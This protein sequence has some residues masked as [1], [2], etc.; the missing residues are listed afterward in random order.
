MSPYYD[1]LLFLLLLICLNLM[2]K[3]KNERESQ[4]DESKTRKI[5][6]NKNTATRDVK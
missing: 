5:T 1:Y 3:K 6:K 2:I 4:V